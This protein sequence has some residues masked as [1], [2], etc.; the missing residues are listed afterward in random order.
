VG[1]AGTSVGG[2]GKGGRKGRAAAHCRQGHLKKRPAYSVSAGGRARGLA[3]GEFSKRRGPRK[4]DPAA[5][6]RRR[7]RLGKVPFYDRSE[8]GKY[9]GIVVRKEM[10]SQ[11]YKQ[12]ELAPVANVSPG[13]LSSLLK[14]KHSV[15][16]LTAERVADALGFELD[17]LKKRA[18]R[19]MRAEQQRDPARQAAQVQ[20][21][22]A[23]AAA[24][25][26]NAKL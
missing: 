10:K 1:D 20:A 4:V 2:N 3:A 24:A 19:L 7:G 21:V 13:A 22:R 11:G 5:L 12:W 26:K 15:V 18:R 16:M 9:F 17:V 8:L 23:A 6:K 25:L 14:G